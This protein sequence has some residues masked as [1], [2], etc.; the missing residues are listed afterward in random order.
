MLTLAVVA[1]VYFLSAYFLKNV[2][3]IHHIPESLNGYS[4]G[5]CVEYNDR[6]YLI[7]K[8]V[9]TKGNVILFDPSTQLKL[10]VKVRRVSRAHWVLLVPEVFVVTKE[11][12]A[13]RVRKDSGS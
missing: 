8:L 1:G 3:P 11:Q 12:K 4:L 7:Q 2:H 9:T 10:T 5:D 6:H 13:T